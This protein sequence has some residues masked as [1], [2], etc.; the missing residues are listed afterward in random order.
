MKVTILFDNTVFEGN[1]KSGWG[2]SSLV[3]A[4]GAPRI[5]FDTGADGKILLSNMAKLNVDPSSIDEVF[6]SH[7]HHDHVGGLS[8]FLAENSDVKLYVPPSYSAPEVEG[9]TFSIR[10]PQQIHENVYSTGELSGVEQSLVVKTEEG[11]VVI[12]G[13]SHPSMNLILETASQ[14]GEP[15]GII[16]GLHGTKAKSLEGLKLICATHCT[17]HKKEIKSRFPDAYVEGGA[18]KVIQI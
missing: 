14:F 2:F 18:G 1:L 8:N 4:E 9:G 11:V 3:E 13:C 15:S 6:I 5:L 12:A 17:Q 16:G 7:A 10:E